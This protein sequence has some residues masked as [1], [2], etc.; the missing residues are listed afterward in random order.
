MII[1]SSKFF[2]AIT[3]HMEA[4]GL[5]TNDPPKQNRWISI[6]HKKLHPVQYKKLWRV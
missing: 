3:M 6:M 4:Q 5:M 1:K 2:K